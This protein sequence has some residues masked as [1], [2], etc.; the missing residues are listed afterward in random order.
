MSSFVMGYIDTEIHYCPYCGER[1]TMIDL[2]GDTVC[3]KCGKSFCV[4]EG[5]SED[6]E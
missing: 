6:E 5:E 2:I 3:E 4:I 1:L